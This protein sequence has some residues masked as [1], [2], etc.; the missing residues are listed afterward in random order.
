MAR[1]RRSPRRR[2]R[3][4]PG[5]TWGGSR[6]RQATRCGPQRRCECTRSAVG[7]SG[8]RRPRVGA[9]GVGWL[10]D[11]AALRVREWCAE[12]RGGALSHGSERLR[13]SALPPAR[14]TPRC[15]AWQ[16]QSCS[17]RTART[18]GG[19]QGG[20]TCAVQLWGLHR[21]RALVRRSAAGTPPQKTRE[22]AGALPT[23][24][25][26]SSTSPAGGRRAGT[27]AVWTGTSWRESH[28]ARG[29]CAERRS[30]DGLW[31]LL[32]AARLR[33]R[34]R[35]RALCAGAGGGSPWLVHRRG[36]RE[37]RVGTDTLRCLP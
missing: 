24:A 13:V 21:A 8:G 22:R 3:R 4:R 16:A 23:A 17:Q 29:P 12:A 5:R 14:R 18:L 19:Q 6:R 31:S 28:S 2:R 37:R 15:A 11:C 26:L 20:R 33:R 35:R 9:G 1:R 25:T 27:R 32:E 34:L 7:S 10:L 30:R 36:A